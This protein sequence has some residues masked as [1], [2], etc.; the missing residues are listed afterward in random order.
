[1]AQRRG[2]QTDNRHPKHVGIWVAGTTYTRSKS[3]IL[4]QREG[5]VNHGSQ[6]KSSP[7]PGRVVE[8][9]GATSS[10]HGLPL[11]RTTPLSL[12][13]ELPVQ[14]RMPVTSTYLPA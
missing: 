10:V 13:P 2:S 7:S 11:I 3:L 6:S 9:N 1:M 12:W 8:E 5:G 4:G 14:M